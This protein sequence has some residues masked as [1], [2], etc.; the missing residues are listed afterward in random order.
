ML[1]QIA[2]KLAES[3][4]SVEARRET[5][6]PRWGDFQKTN[7]PIFTSSDEPLDA[8]DWLRDIERR[9]NTMECSDKERV[10]FATHQLQGPAAAWWVAF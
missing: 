8:D 7:P 9:L 2:T 10:L 6:K 3:R 5:R 1:E 4:E